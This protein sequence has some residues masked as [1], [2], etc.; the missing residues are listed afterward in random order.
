MILL[1]YWCHPRN[2][3]DHVSDPRHNDDDDDDSDRHGDVIVTILR[4]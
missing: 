1:Y 2:V 4:A 3:N